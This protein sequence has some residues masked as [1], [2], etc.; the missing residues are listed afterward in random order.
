[1]PFPKLLTSALKAPS[2]THEQPGIVVVHE[3]IVDDVLEQ[4]LEDCGADVGVLI[5]GDT[6]KGK[7]TLVKAAQGKGMKVSWWEDVWAAGES[8]LDGVEKGMADTGYRDIQLM[9]V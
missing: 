7:Q 4:I 6:A 1:L 3:S 8:S 5:V 9:C 2:T